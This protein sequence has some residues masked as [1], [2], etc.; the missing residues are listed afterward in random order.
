M[1]RCE[2]RSHFLGFDSA[3]SHASRLSALREGL[4]NLGYQEGRNI[5]IDLCWAEGDYTRL[6]VLADEL[7][8]LNVDIILT[9]G[10]AGALA[11]QK[12]TKTIPIVITAVGDMVALGLVSSLARPGGNITRSEEHTSELQS[13]SV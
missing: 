3:S 1:R 13:P 4:R 9:H 6:P 2:A 8:R 5:Q 12:A 11:A 10:A 7:V